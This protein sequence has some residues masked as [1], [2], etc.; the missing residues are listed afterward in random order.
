M[1]LDEEY[2]EWIK[3]L[4]N[5]MKTIEKKKLIMIHQNNI[6]KSDACSHMSNSGVFRN[7]A[8]GGGWNI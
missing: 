3:N 2:K 1:F 8:R 5:G 4:M 7:F 6:I